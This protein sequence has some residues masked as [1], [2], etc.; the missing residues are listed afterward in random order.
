MTNLHLIKLSTHVNSIIDD[1][2]QLSATV[3]SRA[4]S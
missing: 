1:G 2:V 4:D 3:R